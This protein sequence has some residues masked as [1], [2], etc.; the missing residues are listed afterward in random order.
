MIGRRGRLRFLSHLETSQAWIRALR[1][2]R[3]PL[4][5][6]QGFHAHPKVTFATALPVGEESDMELMDVVLQE[7]CDPADALER[8]QRQLPVGLS[9]TSVE[10]VALNAASLMAS[11]IGNA[12]MLTPSTPPATLA[13]RIEELNRMDAWPVERTVKDRAK[14]G[15]N[16]RKAISWI[17]APRHGTALRSP[18]RPGR[19]GKGP[20]FDRARRRAPGKAQGDHGPAGTRSGQDT[21]TQNRLQVDGRCLMRRTV[22]TLRE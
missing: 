6:S 12:Y 4:A 10:E 14:G 19:C 3:L 20:F 2:A 1:R 13:A 22:P 16:A 11:L 7:R 21:G 17:S 15:K 5:Y 9:A 8:L 18:D